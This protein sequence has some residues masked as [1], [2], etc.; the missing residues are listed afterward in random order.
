MYSF[1]QILLVL[2]ITDSVLILPWDAAHTHL[3]HSGHE[4]ACSDDAYDW[5]RLFFSR[6]FSIS[7]FTHRTANIPY[8]L[9][10]G[11]PPSR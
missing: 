2:I 5:T 8:R 10:C 7:S 6:V 4:H 3:V 1:T 9:K 11:L